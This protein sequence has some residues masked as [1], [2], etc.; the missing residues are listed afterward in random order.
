[1]QRRDLLQERHSTSQPRRQKLP[2]RF[3]V[4]PRDQMSRVGFFIEA[5]AG[6]HPKIDQLVQLFFGQA[7]EIAD[8]VGDEI[9]AC[10]CALKIER[11]QRKI[12]SCRTE[13]F[14]SQKTRHGTPAEGYPASFGAAARDPKARARMTLRTPSVFSPTR[15]RKFS[16]VT[17]FKNRSFRSSGFSAAPFFGLPEGARR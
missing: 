5:V 6:P 3:L 13:S 9:P 11:Q 14:G 17:R 10:S 4:G 2:L 8:H 7:N 16:S 1:M 15:A 12:F